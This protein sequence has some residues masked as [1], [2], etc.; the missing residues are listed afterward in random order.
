MSFHCDMNK[1]KFL[2]LL[3]DKKVQNYSYNIFFFIVF[4]FFI[5]F[6]I[7]P[8]LITAFNLQ[9]ELQDLRLKN[10]QSEE[11]ILQIVNYQSLMEEYRDSLYVLDDAVPS[12]PKLAQFVEEISQT[13]TDSGLVVQSLTVESI[14]FKGQVGGDQESID[15]SSEAITPQADPDNPEQAVDESGDGEKSIDESSL[16]PKSPEL[17]SFTITVDGAATV[18]QIAQFLNQILAQRRLKTYDSLT[19]STAKATANTVINIL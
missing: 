16:V 19:L 12:S 13:A 17:L 6:A 5:I 10:K 4:T 1:E 15:G 11:V 18:P 3:K 8:N 7:R 2:A 9:K 14:A